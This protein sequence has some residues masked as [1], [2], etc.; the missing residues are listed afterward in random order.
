MIR[1]IKIAVARRR[2]EAARVRCTKDTSFRTFSRY[3]RLKNE[4]YRLENPDAIPSA[5]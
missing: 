4:L 3:L 1:K 2:C 5:W